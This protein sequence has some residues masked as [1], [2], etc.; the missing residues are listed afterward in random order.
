MGFSFLLQDSVHTLT[1]AIMLL[2]TDMHG[3]L[4]GAPRKMTCAEFVEN[5]S[6]L[7]DGH[8]FPRD[9]LKNIY[10]AIKSE[11]IPCARD[12]DEE[13][14]A[15]G[16]AAAAAANGQPSPPTTGGQINPQVRNAFSQFGGL[17]FF[18]QIHSGLF[19]RISL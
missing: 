15:A 2:N 6:E 19:I 17:I 4:T 3:G 7:N 18:R 1:C 12:E 16:A 13:A 11:A 5:L 10:F 9:L 14:A 8:D